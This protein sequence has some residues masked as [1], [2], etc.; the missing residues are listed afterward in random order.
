MKIG[1]NGL[2]R[3]GRDILR[4]ALKR[5]DIEVVAVNHKSRRIAV[6]DTYAQSVAH[7]IKYD[8]IHGTFDAEVSARDNRTIVVDGHEVLL[9]AEGDPTLL[10]WKELGVEFVVESTGRFNNKEDASKHIQAG[11]RKVVISAPAKGECMTIVMGVNED[12]Y[13]PSQHHVVS[14]ASCTTNCLAP[15]AKVLH[16]NFGIEKGLMTTVHAYTNDQQLL[17]MPHRDMRR[18]RAANLNII[19]HHRGSQV[20]GLVLPN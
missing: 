4:C 12:Q 5:P 20:S 11:A 2:G 10:P 15:V 18:S 14:N 8:S 9:L 16:E 17:D 1:I 13:D 19:P 3:I 7:M 6:T